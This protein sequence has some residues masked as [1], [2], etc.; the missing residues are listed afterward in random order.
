MVDVKKFKNISF[1]ARNDCVVCGRKSS[2]AVI[3]WPKLPLTEFYVPYPI[4]ER[5][6]FVDQRFHLCPYC[7]HGQLGNVVDQNLLYGQGY[8]TRTSSSPSA[9]QAVNVF[10]D[11]IKKILKGKTVKTVV[12]IGCNDTYLLQKFNDGRKK[13]YGIDPIWKN[14][15]KKD[16]NIGI[17]VIGSFFE[18]INLTE[19]IPG[20]DVILCSHTLEHME[21]PKKVLS[22]L[23]ESAD[24]KTMFF[25]QFPGLEQLL[26]DARF[27]QI[28]H[29]HLN[30]F[31]L[32]SFCC[33]L[34]VVGAELVDSRVNAYHW[35]ARMVAF[36]K[37]RTT[38]LNQKRFCTNITPWS[39]HKVLCQYA[40]FRSNMEATQKRLKAL[41]H[42]RLLGYGAAQMLPVL[43]YHLGGLDCLE[44]IVDD[45]VRKKGLCYVNVPVVIK[46]PSDIHDMKKAVVLVTAI[47]SLK[48]LRMIIARL[49]KEEIEEIIIPVNAI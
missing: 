34:D 48:P 29:Q 40:I 23:L 1:K 18:E 28:F 7:G 31:S 9:S 19:M 20:I 35:G 44:A 25:F 30:Y 43:D 33:L 42:K 15:K 21:D 39:R 12:E 13:L 47:N 6:G 24:P 4:K 10:Y 38:F 17:N 8:W 5:L 37:K 11:F 45:D 16:F 14:K 27:D 49:I 36:R 3:A 2:E 46:H 41:S 32:K 22:K 26:Q